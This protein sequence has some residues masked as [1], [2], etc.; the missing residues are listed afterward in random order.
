MTS[1]PCV[2]RS[3]AHDVTRRISARGARL[4]PHLLRPSL[5][6]HARP[7]ILAP[8]ASPPPRFP[9]GST[10][11][12][13]GRAMPSPRSGPAATSPCS[14]PIRP[15]RTCPPAAATS[16]RL[17]RLPWRSSPPASSPSDGSVAR[18]TRLPDPPQHVQLP[19]PRRADARP[20]PR[21]PRHVQISVASSVLEMQLNHQEHQDHQENKEEERGKGIKKGGRRDRGGLLPISWSRDNGNHGCGCSVGDGSVGSLR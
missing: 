18:W 6:H 17:L 19:P 14:W 1:I 11:S 5:S 4:R 20:G 13:T 9:T 12:T 16:T 7:A 3:S 2:P 8:R 21:P 15:R 10:S